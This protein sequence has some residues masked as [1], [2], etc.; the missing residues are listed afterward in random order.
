MIRQRPGVDKGERLRTWGP[1]QDPHP[2]LLQSLAREDTAHGAPSPPPLE[3]LSPP[4][5]LSFVQK[6]RE[7]S[8][9]HHFLCQTPPFSKPH[10]AGPAKCPHHRVVVKNKRDDNGNNKN[11]NLSGY[12]SQSSN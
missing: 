9:L 8:G 12:Q 5:L 2:S 4:T 7:A 1:L 3:M 11:P 6:A 10:F